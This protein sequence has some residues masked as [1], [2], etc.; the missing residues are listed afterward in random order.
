LSDTEADPLVLTSK[1]VASVLQRF[2]AGEISADDAQRWASLMRWGR[3]SDAACE[4]TVSFEIEYE[5]QFELAIAE[6][7]GRLTELGDVVDGE[8]RPGEA[9]EL[10]RALEAV[11]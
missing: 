1:T 7:I 8:L 11:E 9:A 5:E 4:L 10:L 2:V 3:M 6:S